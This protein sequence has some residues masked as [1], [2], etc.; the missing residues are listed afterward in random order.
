MR[1]AEENSNRRSGNVQRDRSRHLVLLGILF[2]TAGIHAG[3]TEQS[4]RPLQADAGRPTTQVLRPDAIKFVGTNQTTA[5]E[6][7]VVEDGR[8]LA[9]AVA[10]LERQFGW[11][12][13]YEDPPYIFKGD[14]SDVT[15]MVRRD[16]DKYPPGEAPRVL[17]PKGGRFVFHY[18]AS[19]RR[20]PLVLLRQLVIAYH[21]NIGAAK[22]QVE[23]SDKA[24]H[25]IPVAVRGVS[26]KEV[27]DRSPLNIAIT[28]PI[29]V[30]TGMQELEELCAIIS[31]L[32][33]S[34]VVV[35]TIPVGMFSRSLGK[36]GGSRIIARHAI[37][38]L[39]EKTAHGLKLSWRLLYGPDTKMYALNIHEIR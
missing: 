31:K 7:L 17:V 1:K 23:K 2:V 22:F 4:R 38:D 6:V 25:I 14:I 30:R 26:G 12:I 39:L 5:R 33:H 24:F 37:E 16:L 29:K 8:P 9:K 36:R 10:E 34:R 19:L 15:A 18:D 35:G 20:D 21:S 28:L 3:P 32:S 13:T 11:V 27:L